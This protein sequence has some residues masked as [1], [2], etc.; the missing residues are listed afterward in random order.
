MVKAG[1]KY[2]ELIKS[3]IEIS[4]EF[5]TKRLIKYGFSKAFI[6]ELKENITK[7]EIRQQIDKAIADNESEN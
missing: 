2:F 5:V 6:N 3:K 4:P 1:D 7:N